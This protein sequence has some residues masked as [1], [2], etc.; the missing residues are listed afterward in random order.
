MTCSYAAWVAAIERH[1]R[2]VLVGSL[3]C[4]LLSA[5]SLTRLRLDFD[6]LSM[7]PT[8]SPAFDDFKSFVGDFGQLNELAVLVEG[9]PIDR[10]REFADTFGAR[11]TA[12]DTVT[13]VQARVDVD[14][15]LQGVFGRY[16]YNYLPENEYTAFEQRL[17][18][19]GID[20]QVAANRTIL[21]APFDLS[22]ATAVLQDPFGLRRLAA[23][24]L[25]ESYGRDANW[26]DGYLTAPDQSALLVLV[27]PTESAFDIAF[28]ARLMQDVRRAE[29]EARRALPFGDD[30][31]VRYA[32]SYVYALEDAATLRWDVRRYTLLALV[33]VLGVFYAGYRSWRILPF[34]TY[35]LVVTTLVTFALSLLLF[36]QLN[37]VSIAFAAILYGL[38]IDS[39][40]HFYARLMQERRHQDVRGAVTTTLA[41]LGR[42]NIGAS[43]TTAAA[44]FVIGFS[45]LRGV[46]QLGVLTGIGMLL[47]ILE[48]FTLYPALGFIMARTGRERGGSLE[49]P[50]VARL[51]GAAVARARS[52][53]I[54]AVLVGAGLLWAAS[55]VGLDVTLTHLRPRASEAARAEDEIVA[56]FGAQAPG[57]AV[58]VRAARLDDALVGGE[59]VTD[60]LVSYER[61]GLLRSVRSVRGLLPSAQAQRLRLARYNQLPRAAAVEQLREALTRHGFVAQRFEGFFADFRQP[62]EELITLESPV[63]EPIRFLIDHHV[64]SRV[65][66]YFVATFVQPASGVTL[67][68]AV[69]RL[70]R[71]LPDTPFVFAARSLL[72]EELERVL[73]R[74]FALFL[75]LALT[76]NAALLLL[77]F[78]SVRMTLAIL[79]PELLALIALFAGMRFFGVAIDPV[80]LVVASLVLGLGVDYGVYLT[81]EAGAGGGVVAAVRQRGRAVIV[82]SLTTVAGFGF[83]GLSRY[84]ALA[85]MG[86]LSGAGL[87]LAL[88][89]SFTLLPAVMASAGTSTAVGEGSSTG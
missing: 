86:I 26:S 76:G 65:G 4:C 77:T 23:R 16:L 33:G 49:T 87:M 88:L 27:R 85:T 30:V 29:A 48:F 6:V 12:L 28:T 73:G 75:M 82:T 8:G 60:R 36:D 21:S 63:L 89:L 51:A 67:R 2:L 20:R 10:L 50:R 62:H 18:P 1:R 81:A 25:A 19:E 57:G 52:I 44:F 32:G 11:L 37:A 35:P 79:A 83:L 45:C 80:N 55:H 7:L 59:A 24:A 64:R 74:E 9:A 40:I 22:A 68:A 71:D 46:K 31:R 43:G 69:E 54:A 66:E 72:E 13:G 58:L 3:L 5:L 78:G 84:P 38:S 34:V 39:G 53:R 47:T 14:R 70:R 56:R 17:T 41:A 42:A 61:E 15:I